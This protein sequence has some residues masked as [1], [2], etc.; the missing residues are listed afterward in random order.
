MDFV[1]RTA[2]SRLSRRRAI[3]AG[4]SALAVGLTR[5]GH[6]AASEPLPSAITAVMS[7]PRYA[8]ST[9]NLFVTDLATGQSV[10]ELEPDQLALTG[11]VRKLFS[12]GLA[13]QQLGADHRFTTPVY[14]L[15]TVDSQG[16]LDGDLV[17]VAAGDLTLGGRVTSE[18]DIAVT[19]FDHNDA[20]NLG[21]AIL[22]P[23]DP[24]HGLDSL[25]EQ[26]R[27]SGIRNVAGD[28]V[29]D[30][31]LFESFRVPNGNLLIT[32]ILVNENMVDVTITPTRPGEAATVSWRPHTGA[33]AVD[34]GVTTTAAGTP[35]TVTLSGNGRVECIGSDGCTGSVEG[36]IPVGYRAPLSSQPDLVQTFRIED[37]P[38]FAR[39]AFIEALQR[40]G[41]TVAASP[42]GSQS[43]RTR[44][45]RW[46]P[47]R[48][49]PASR[50]FTSPPY[51][52]YA[53]L[54]LKVSLN[55]GANLSLMLF[56][57]AH[58]KRTIAE[59]LAVERQTLIDDFGLQPDSFNFPTNGS[60]S[61][62]SQATARATV[63]LLEQMA[64]TSG[65]TKTLKVAPV[66]EAG[67]QSISRMYRS[68]R[69]VA[70]SPGMVMAC[71]ES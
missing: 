35:D 53:R 68:S 47:T 42:V 24:L 49:T 39:T 7:K 28:V 22:T 50:T 17:L 61:P 43:G 41:V 10:Y 59:A 21:T 38:A 58:G 11:S 33:F 45:L 71:C 36:D 56:G 5:W 55:L 51:A 32:P 4:G 46:T 63:Q 23:Q 19:T 26:V 13:L 15:G 8:E 25:A 14:R 34:A 16:T 54:I 9:W 18:D 57:L 64:L 6:T 67:S 52:G 29:I 40:V 65:L 69:N 66:V 27:A 62:D 1:S 3:L 2:A 31:R 60:G 70:R 48:Q 37:P 30:D 44:C 20:N 12:V